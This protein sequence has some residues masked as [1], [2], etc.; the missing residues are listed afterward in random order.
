[1]PRF[2]INGNL[3]R[4]DTKRQQQFEN[5][6]SQQEL[7]MRQQGSMVNQLASLY[8]ISNDAQMT[9]ERIAQMQAQTAAVQSQTAGQNIQNDW[10]PYHQSLVGQGLE[11]DLV[12]KRSDAAWEEPTKQMQ[13]NAGV[14]QTNMANAQTQHL[15]NPYMQMAPYFMQQLGLTPEEASQLFLPPAMQK[16][17]AATAAQKEQERLAAKAKEDAQAAATP[18]KKSKFDLRSMTGLTPMFPY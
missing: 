7:D 11:A 4:M 13:Y 15:G 14:A 2:N 8:G 6:A 5:D 17:R 3:S 9:P 1:M 12:G 18:P 16:T 10:S